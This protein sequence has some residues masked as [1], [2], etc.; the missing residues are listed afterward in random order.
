MS[1]SQINEIDFWFEFASPYSF[2]SAMRIEK[3]ADHNDL[4]INWQPLLLG[5]IFKSYGWETSPFNLFP[6]KGRYMWQ[7]VKRRCQKFSIAFKKPNVFPAHS[8]LATRVVYSLRYD[9]QISS[10]IK[11]IYQAHFQQN[12]DI[13]KP[14]TLEKILPCF[15]FK[16]SEIIERS[17]SSEN[18]EALKNHMIKAEKLGIFGAP[19]FI[20]NNELFWGDDRLE[21]TTLSYTSS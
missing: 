15:G 10:I 17:L 19:S 2:I 1:K 9:S 13:A 5:P 11:A 14:Q 3:W 8:L 4:K 18:K 6:E 20:Y 7:D 16:G 12:L 21:E